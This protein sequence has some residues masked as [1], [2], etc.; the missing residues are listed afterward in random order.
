M[1]GLSE[2]CGEFG[3]FCFICEGLVDE[4]VGLSEGPWG[5]MIT[6]MIL[7]RAMALWRVLAGRAYLS[8]E[9]GIKAI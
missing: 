8:V 1:P 4:G 5:W 7:C 2:E 3:C 6:L 9:K